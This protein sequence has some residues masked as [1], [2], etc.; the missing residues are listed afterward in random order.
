[1]DGTQEIVLKPGQQ[2]AFRQ[3]KDFID[4]PNARVFILCGY[5]GT[6]KTTL[7]R[8][9]LAELNARQR[10]YR[11]LASTG[12]AAKILANLTGDKEGASTIHSMIYCFRGLNQDLSNIDTTKVEVSGQLILTLNP[13]LLMRNVTRREWSI[14]LTRHR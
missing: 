5:A 11:L 1:M 7:M 9:L 4:T 2:K 13:Q 14:L 12:R 3:L 8:F 6:G 10:P